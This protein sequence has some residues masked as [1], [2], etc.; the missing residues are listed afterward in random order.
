[1]TLLIIYRETNCVA[2]YLPNLGHS[3]D[4]GLHIF[5]FLDRGPSYW[6][7]Y[8]IIGVSLTRSIRVLSNV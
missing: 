2:D 6:F 1:V 5:D 4:F 3:V 8:D 7:R